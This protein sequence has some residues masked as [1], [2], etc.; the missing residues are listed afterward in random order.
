V[1]HWSGWPIRKGGRYSGV[2]IADASLTVPKLGERFADYCQI[3]GRQRCT[4]TVLAPALARRY[5]TGETLL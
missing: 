4:T 2:E 1:R 3:G 5:L